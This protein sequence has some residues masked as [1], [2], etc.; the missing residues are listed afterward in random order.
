MFINA[1]A[2]NRPVLGITFATF[3]AMAGGNASSLDLVTYDFVGGSAAPT[4]LNPVVTASDYDARSAEFDPGQ[5]AVSSTTGTAFVRLTGTPATSNPTMSNAYHTFSIEITGLGS[6]EVINLTSLDLTYGA[7]FASQFIRLYSDV[8]GL[9]GTDDIIDG[10]DAEFLSEAISFD[11][12]NENSRAGDVFTGLT[13]GD[14][15]EFRF[16]FGDTSSDNGEF[17]RTSNIAL[18][19]DIVPEPSS[20]ALLGLGGLAMLRRRRR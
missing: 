13:N 7:N 20:L 15:I 1:K 11:L 17:H 6:D 19:G 2:I 18:V 8:S 4:T 9:T 3:T 12:T 14:A 10:H 5:S 16:Y